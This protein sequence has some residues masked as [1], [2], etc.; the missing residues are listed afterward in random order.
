[1]RPEVY[2]VIM[3]NKATAEIEAVQASFKGI[4]QNMNGCPHRHKRAE[5]L[6]AC[7]M[8][9]MRPCVYE[10]GDG[11][12]ELFQEILEEWRMMYEIC[13]ECGE[14]RSG[15]ERVRAGMKCGICA[16]YL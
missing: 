14:V 2:D 5:G 1:M 16:G 13:P 9:E 3:D 8:N 10:T 12:C 6:D 4:W 11:P 15:D 7:E